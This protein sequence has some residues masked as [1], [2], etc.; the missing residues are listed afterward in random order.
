MPDEPREFALLCPRCGEENPP[1]FPVCWSCHGDLPGSAPAPKR[2]PAA[3]VAH[4]PRDR[5]AETARRKRIAL[6]V[7]VA[8]SIVWLPWIGGGIWNAFDPSPPQTWAVL[9]WSSAE[10]AGILGLLAYFAWLDGDWRRLLGL[11]R[12][13]IGREIAWGA[14]TFVAIVVADRLA[15]QITSLFGLESSSSPT[16]F[17]PSV[18]WLVPAHLLLGALVEETFYRAYL[19]NRLTELTGRPAL[20]I[21]ITALLFSAA[22][23]YRLSDSIALVFFGLV[24]GWIFRARRSLWPLVLAHWAFNLSV[25]FT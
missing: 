16:L 3:A 17:E 22:H 23:F 7:V 5:I 13:S 12:P 9:L 14:A 21:A 4:H 1:E 8:M 20:S 10:C 19:W 11:A 18:M 2:E 15:Y 24:L 25:V 6:E